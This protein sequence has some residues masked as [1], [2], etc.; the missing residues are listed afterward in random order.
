MG[1]AN[2]MTALAAGVRTLDS[3]IGGLGGCPYSP[4]YVHPFLALNL[5][6][7]VNFLHS[8]TGNVATEDI[9]YALK[10]SPYHTPN[11]TEDKLEDVAKI[12]W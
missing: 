7:I 1:V 10:D 8:A 4:G 12:G 6:L 9:L 3:S 5:C 11:R 2:A